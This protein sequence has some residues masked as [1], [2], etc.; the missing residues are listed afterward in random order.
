MLLYSTACCLFCG[1]LSVPKPGLWQPSRDPHSHETPPR[2]PFSPPRIP[3]PR[4][5]PSPQSLTATANL[6]LDPLAWCWDGMCRRALWEARVWCREE[7]KVLYASLKYP[8][9]RLVWDN[10]D[11]ASLLLGPFWRLL[12]SDGVSKFSSCFWRFSC[13]S[14]LGRCSARRQLCRAVLW[15][16]L[17]YVH[18]VGYSSPS[19]I[20]HIPLSAWGS[21]SAQSVVR[22]VLLELVMVPT[23]AENEQGPGLGHCMTVADAPPRREGSWWE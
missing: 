7:K 10:A 8:R 15:S 20:I 9:R 21:A 2:N 17:L 16:M 5:R 6:S 11:A 23:L 18:T 19:L 14:L 22:P 3:R 12:R 13:T 1:A 4:P